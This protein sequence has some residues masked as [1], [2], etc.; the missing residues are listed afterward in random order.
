MFAAWKFCNFGISSQLF[1]FFFFSPTSKHVFYLGAIQTVF[2]IAA[3][4]FNSVKGKRCDG[5]SRTDWGWKGMKVGGWVG[6][7]G[8]YRRVR[9]EKLRRSSI[10]WLSPVERAIK[11]VNLKFQLYFRGVHVQMTS[12]ST[13]KFTGFPLVHISREYI[14]FRRITFDYTSKNRHFFLINSLCS[15]FSEREQKKSRK[16]TSKIFT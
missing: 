13:L 6:T 2:R 7:V 10:K 5:R 15:V 1:L 3:M 9:W 14:S 12:F 8:P 16:V 11:H 4:P